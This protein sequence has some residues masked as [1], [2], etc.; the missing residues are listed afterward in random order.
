MTLAELEP[1]RERLTSKQW[2]IAVSLASGASGNETMA[3]TGA[4]GMTYY[5]LVYEIEAIVGRRIRR[6][7]GF[8]K[9]N[10]NRSKRAEGRDRCPV[11]HLLMPHECIT[12]EIG[13]A[14]GRDEEWPWRG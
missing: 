12:A 13:A 6:P 3:K 4:W 14:M 1:F 10:G 2:E 9:Q 5:G 11:C 7:P 8:R